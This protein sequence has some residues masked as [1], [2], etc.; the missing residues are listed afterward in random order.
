LSSVIIPATKSLTITNKFTDGNLNEDTIIVGNDGEY[1]YFSYLFFDISRIPVD[2]SIYNAE[3][4]LFKTNNFYNDSSKEF[5]LCQLSD[6]F[7]SYSTFENR[8]K[9]NPFMKIFFYPITTKVA[10]TVNLTDL[11]IWWVKNKLTNTSIAL[12]NI[13]K[14]ILAEFG[15]SICKDTYLTPYINVSTRPTIRHT[16]PC[17]NN[18]DSPTTEQITIIGT[19][20]PASIYDSIVNVMVTRGVSGRTDNYYISMEYDNSLNSIP[21]HINRTYNMAIIPKICPNDL[22]TVTFYGSYKV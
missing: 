1:R 4:V 11:F 20:A 6:Y 15:S 8:P 13:Q 7:S 5:C 21:L 12:F 2:A 14:N 19:V 17:S 22:E 16:T 18:S 9:I 3:L 10:V